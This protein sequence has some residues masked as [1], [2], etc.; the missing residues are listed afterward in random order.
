MLMN[1]SEI[2]DNVNKSTDLSLETRLANHP[3]IDDV[4]DELEKIEKQK[5]EEMNSYINAF[6]SKTNSDG[7]DVDEEQ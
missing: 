6:Q 3:W 2:I 1:E 5:D 7:D 4:D